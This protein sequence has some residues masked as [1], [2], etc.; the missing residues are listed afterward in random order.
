MNFG[1]F[2]VTSVL[3]LITLGSVACS[4][5][6]P[7]EK[8]MEFSRSKNNK[9]LL[10]EGEQLLVQS[11]AL[12]KELQDNFRIL[13][14]DSPVQVASGVTIDHKTV[15]REFN[16]ARLT[17]TER[18]TAKEKLASLMTAYTRILEIDT[19]R[20][21]YVTHLEK[22]RD[23]KAATES[24]QISLSTFERIRGEQY[25]PATPGQGPV[26]KNID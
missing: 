21:V 9:V 25:N 10:A 19:K 24:H 1:R 4:K 12:R 5:G 2:F 7:S 16:W 13:I 26:Y 6:R 14:A 11:D 20:G 17:L 3:A 15:G 18:Q 8:S 23:R 22:V